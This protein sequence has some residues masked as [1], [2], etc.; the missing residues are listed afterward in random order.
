MTLTD[1]G[2][3]SLDVKINGISYSARGKRASWIFLALV[4][5][6]LYLSSS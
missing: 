1:N 2:T 4:G 6:W 3:S 5:A